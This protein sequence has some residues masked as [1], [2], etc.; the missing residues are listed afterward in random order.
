MVTCLFS[1]LSQR[2]HLFD[3]MVIQLTRGGPAPGSWNNLVTHSKKYQKFC[4]LLHIAPFPIS[5]QNFCRYMAYLTFSLTSAD[6]VLSYLSGVKKLHAYA[7]V[8]MPHLSPYV[9]TVFSGIKRSL[10]Y[11]IHQA[12]PVTP[13]I[14]KQI[15]ASVDHSDCKQVVCFTALVVG[16]YLFLRAS[17]LTTW[18]Q[19]SFNPERNLSRGDI[20]L[21][22]DLALIEIKWS[23][24]IQYFEKTLLIP[25]VKIM[26]P[27]ICPITWIYHMITLI[28]AS[29]NHPAF[30]LFNKKG[31]LVP[32][33][34]Q[35]VSDQFKKWIA[36]IGQNPASHSL[37]GLR[38]GGVTFAFDS[39]LSSET[40]KLLG[41]WASDSFRWYIDH[42]LQQRI[43][44]MTMVSHRCQSL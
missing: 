21:S 39:D 6:S 18:T 25:I 34:Y 8:P 28:S 7:R 10:A 33:T 22:P 32:L 38:R 5:E 14:L 35:T 42:N 30:C 12:E 16:F 23:K 2:S 36:L 17:N 4:Q 15:S 20:R 27:E 29:P 24:T 3:D 43:C 19:T 9:D 37:H 44:A 1:V 31:E 41:D 26:L 40:I 11:Q 13:Q